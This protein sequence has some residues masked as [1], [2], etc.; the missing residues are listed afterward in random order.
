[1]LPDPRTLLEVLQA[2]ADA[3]GAEYRRY[4]LDWLQREIGF[5]GVVWGV[6]RCGAGGEVTISG[7]ELRGR[8]A[9]LLHDYGE[10]AALDPISQRFAKDPRALQAV[11]VARDYAA[12]ALAPVRE[13]LEQYRVRQFL[14]CG[15]ASGQGAL[16]WLTLYREDG[17]R[18]FEQ[19]EAEF[20]AFAIPFA[21]LAGRDASRPEGLGAPPA[22]TARER[23]VAAAYAAGE[24]YKAIARSL[25]LAPATVRTH[26]QAIFR[27]LGVHHKIAL[28]QYLDGP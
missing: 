18:P 20:A 22:L 8:P 15:A 7:A 27:K 21:L 14:L 6:G 13:Y 26:L 3:G 12:P 24:G 5:D 1:M 2:A 23:Q 19:K 25:G 17:A 9:G 10:V 16:S 4:V 28:R 11:A